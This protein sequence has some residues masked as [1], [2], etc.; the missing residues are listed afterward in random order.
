MA[1]RYKNLIYIHIPKTGGTSIRNCIIKVGGSPCGVKHIRYDELKTNQDYFVSV[2]NPYTRLMSWYY[3]RIRRFNEEID[4]GKGD[5]ITPEWRANGWTTN[6]ALEYYNEGFRNWLMNLDT[7]NVF[8]KVKGSHVHFNPDWGAVCKQ[9]D[10]ISKQKPPK[11][12]L[13]Q[14]SLTQDF[15][16]VQK[17]LGISKNLFNQN[18][19]KNDNRYLDVFDD[20]MKE[21]V[22]EY[23]KD[24][25]EY[26]GYEK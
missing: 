21:F 11:F 7:V 25:F 14:E 12:I 26:F 5:N 22:T 18:Q 6:Q 24:D 13:R 20:E 8:E 23:W 2:R 17:Y 10:F 1:V 16:E 9:T 19:S 15:K 4:S 3:F